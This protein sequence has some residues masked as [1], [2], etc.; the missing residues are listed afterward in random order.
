MPMI[1]LRDVRLLVLLVLAPILFSN[2]VRE[3]FCMYQALLLCTVLQ[4]SLLSHKFIKF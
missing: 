2:G 4:N 3:T 1:V